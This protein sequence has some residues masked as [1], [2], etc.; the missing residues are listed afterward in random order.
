MSDQPKNEIIYPEGTQSSAC[1]ETQE[2]PKRKPLVERVKST[3]PVEESATAP[4]PVLAP[5]PE[6]EPVSLIKFDTIASIVKEANER[7]PICLCMIVKNEEHVIE[8]SLNSAA[9]FVSTYVICDTGST[10]K[11]KELITKTM[12]KHGI[13]GLI[14][15]SPW[16]NFGHNRSI[17]LEEAR[18][19]TGN[20]GW[21]WMLDADDS[22]EGKPMPESFWKSV[23]PNINAFRVRIH[24]G[25]IKHQRTQVFS[26]KKRWTFKGAVHEWPALA[27]GEGEEIQ[28]MMPDQVWHTARCEGSRS[29]DPLKYVRDALALRAE[30]QKTPNEPR[31]AFYMAQSFR[32]AGLLEEAKLAYKKRIEI[33][34]GWVQEK[35]MSYVNLIKLAPTVEEKIQ[36]CWKALQLD[37]DRLEAPYYT[38]HAARTMNKFSQEAYALACVVENRES[39]DSFLFPEPDVYKWQYDDEVAV[40]A[41]W[42]NHD[43]RS[44]DAA[45]RAVQ[46]GPAYAKER[47]QKNVDFALE[48]MKKKREAAGK[49]V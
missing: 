6:P 33:E 25:N 15:D 35:Y 44:A 21:S 11:T 27:E 8:R 19:H 26:N 2:K 37:S 17:A 1:Q 28:A 49:K 32:D 39:R 29:A 22:L 31:A 40:I 9:P 48:R 5:E 38:L 12:D 13:K 18:K 30:L 34:T 36:L 23:A 46:N 20:K 16:V 43:K 42:M 41:Y 14:I 7:T 3:V 24:H 4:A 47:L 45:L 10:D